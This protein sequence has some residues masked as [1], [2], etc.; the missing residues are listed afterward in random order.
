[1]SKNVATA[2]NLT[3]LLTQKDRQMDCFYTHPEI[4]YQC[5]EF[6]FQKTDQKS[7]S[8]WVEPSAGN[9][10]FFN[11]MP[12]PK[13]GIDLVPNKKFGILKAD[14]L[15]WN[16]KIEC[17]RIV[18][19]GNPPFGKNSSLAVKFFNHAS[20]FSNCIAMI[21][22]KTFRKDSI[23]NRLN[24]NFHL[25][26]EMDIPENSFIFQNSSYNVPCVFQVWIKKRKLRELVVRPK[27]HT[28]FLFS[29]PVNADFAIQRVGGNAGRVK[30]RLSCISPNSHYFIKSIELVETVT[31][32]FKDIEWSTVK[33][34]TAGNPSISKTDVVSLYSSQKQIVKV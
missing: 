13:T 27:F 18:T 24:R 10:S 25:I 12:E 28:D 1:M 8:H 6:L 21:L 20:S 9:G 14:F 17:K 3:S 26:G 32:I 16:P 15:A 7:F 31:N 33:Y 11:Q 4:A 19:V 23:V 29:E 5:L 34:N 22:P 2:K 30:N